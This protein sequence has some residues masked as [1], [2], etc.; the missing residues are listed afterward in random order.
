MMWCDMTQHYHIFNIRQMVRQTDRHLNSK[1]YHALFHHSNL[2]EI[3]N[4]NVLYCSP[5]L[6]SIFSSKML[7]WTLIQKSIEISIN[8]I[9]LICRSNTLGSPSP[10]PVSNTTNFF[11]M[12]N[13]NIFNKVKSMSMKERT[14]TD[15]KKINPAWGEFW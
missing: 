7:L 4:W 12:K 11:K 3:L 13:L 9:E 8:F 15:K 14:P 10:L 6:F 1:C 2:C 5:Y